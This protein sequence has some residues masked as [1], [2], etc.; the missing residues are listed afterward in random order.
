M[1]WHSIHRTRPSGLWPQVGTGVIAVGA[2]LIA[3]AA[4]KSTTSTIRGVSHLHP[5]QTL[6]NFGVAVVVAGFVLIACLIVLAIIQWV[7]GQVSPFRLEFAPERYPECREK[8]PNGV[9]SRVRVEN[10]RGVGLERVRL[11]M[12][13]RF[14]VGYES[15]AHRMHDASVDKQSSKDGCDL[16][17]KDS[18]Y[19]DI[20]WHQPNVVVL[21]FAEDH[22]RS[23][24]ALA[25]PLTGPGIILELRAEGWH[26]GWAVR[27]N[28]KSFVVTI[29]EKAGVLQFREVKRKEVERLI[30]EVS[31]VEVDPGLHVAPIDTTEPHGAS[32]VPPASLGG[33]ESQP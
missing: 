29:G 16:G 17:P 19:F 24:Q 5:D 23:G 14:P 21:E 22:L 32:G 25:A 12:K 27:P 9:Q 11:H 2:V 15:L 7:Q 3:V 10:K 18:T 8:F 20:A 13:R 4:A 26:D 33:Q 30:H 6:L 31:E 1:A 28:S